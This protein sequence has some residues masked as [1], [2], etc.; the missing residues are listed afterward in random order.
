[1]KKQHTV[2]VLLACLLFAMPGMGQDEGPELNLTDCIRIALENNVSINT[3]RNLKQVADN[4][5]KASYSAILPTIDFSTS[6]SKFKAGEAVYV[7][8][9]PV[10][11]DMDGNV[12]FEQQLVTQDPR[13]RDNF[14]LNW[15][16]NQNIFDG[17]NWWNAIK[18]GKI[19]ADLAAHDLIARTN[20]AIRIVAQNY[21]DLLKQQKLMEVNELAVGRSQDN[22]DKTQQMFEIGS[23]AKVD[24]FRARVN[25]GNDKISAI[26]QRNTVMN[27]KQTLNISMGKEPNTSLEISKDFS[28]DY[29]IPSVEELINTA[30]DNNPDIMRQEKD[31][32]STSADVAIAKS[33]YYPR[34]GFFFRYD[35][36]SNDSFSRLYNDLDRNWEM[37]YGLSLSWNLFNGFQDHARVQNSKIQL[38]NVE[39]VYED[40]RRNLESD[41]T[42]LWQRYADLNEIV[43]INRDNLEAAGEEYRLAN[44]RYRL[45]S[46]TSLDLR[47]AQVNLTEAERILVVAEY[48]LIITYAQIQETVGKIQTALT[49]SKQ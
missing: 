11:Q 49:F 37:R 27:S 25:L 3:Y 39:L 35:R 6:A 31:I 15:A 19:D 38:R 43:E 30:F 1:M 14:G 2:V 40:F 17:G 33:A 21:F 47:E 13:E 9:V 34:L 32:E 20:E 26:T 46:G 7:G 48:D 23:V 8:D 42:V 29:A 41:V 24:V 36:N 44:E 22:L 18:K 45:G 28:F 5:V 4:N 16:V 12:I 10:G